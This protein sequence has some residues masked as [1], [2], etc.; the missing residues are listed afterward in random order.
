MPATNALLQEGRYRI[1]SETG[2]ES[3]DT[4]YDAYDT[5]DELNVVVKEIS[6]KISKVSTLS[7]RENANNAF[8]ETANLLTQIEHAIAARR[9]RSF[10]RAWT[11]ISCPGI[12]RRR[13]SSDA[14]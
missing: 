14:A 3:S 2:H 8:A 7:Q 10:L 13:R 12:R 5:V 11:T 6:G 9:P 1:N 4:V